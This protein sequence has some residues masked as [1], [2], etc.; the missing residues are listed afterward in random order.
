MPG[1]SRFLPAALAATL[2]VGLPPLAACSSPPDSGSPAQAAELAQAPSDSALMARGMS[3]IAANDPAG[4]IAAFRQV[5]AA[6]PGHYG[7]RYQLARALDLVGRPVEARQE[8]EQFRPMA[9]R[10]GDSASLAVVG[11]R[12]ARA[13]TLGEA[14]LMARGLEKLHAANAP[15]AAAAD[16][17]QVLE[18]NPRHYGAHFQLATALDRQG[19]AAEARQWWTRLQPMA[20]AVKDSAT[21]ATIRTRLLTVP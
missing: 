18:L 21:L 4:A 9:E 5:L 17:R 2:C 15:A 8:W 10:T 11:P 16:F 13:D 6:T 14:E 12:L 19:Q 3:R 1:L 20:E 7:A